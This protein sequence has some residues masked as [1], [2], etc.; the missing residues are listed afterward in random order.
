MGLGFFCAILADRLPIG[1]AT[2]PY[3]F[4]DLVGVFFGVPTGV[5]GLALALA[6]AI[7]SFL[8]GVEA[9]F[10][11]GVEGA[12]GY[13]DT[14][15]SPPSG[16][17]LIVTDLVMGFALVKPMIMKNPATPTCQVITNYSIVIFQFSFVHFQ[18]LDTK[19][20]HT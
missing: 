9:S 13:S 10:L 4:D 7:S 12:V 14:I 3:W 6:L 1:V 19:T 11:T 5:E 17:S 18:I 2:L 15:L 16:S 20:S 8:T